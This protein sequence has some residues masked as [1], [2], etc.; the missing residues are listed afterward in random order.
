MRYAVELSLKCDAPQLQA[1]T[2]TALAVVLALG[3]RHNDGREAAARAVPVFMAKGD[4]VAALRREN[5]A[6]ALPS[7]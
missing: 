1:Q 6:M 4:L 5:G 2:L 7:P 3:G